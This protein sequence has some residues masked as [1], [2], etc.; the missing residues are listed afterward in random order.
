MRDRTRL[1]ER[2]GLTLVVAAAA[3]FGA[4]LWMAFRLDPLPTGKPEALG[5]DLPEVPTRLTASPT[6]VQTAVDR[7]PFREDRRR[8]PQRYRLPAERREP[9]RLA[10]AVRSVPSPPRLV[11]TASTPDGRGL[12]IFVGRSRAAQVVRV[13]D[14]IDGWRLVKVDGGTATMI[15]SDSTLV[16][17]VDQP[18]SRR[19][20]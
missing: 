20:E 6:A 3:W 17:H 19:R 4:S 11:G 2:A 9:R 16:L 7:N 12:A 15:A 10:T 13:G 1:I 14:E 8:P 18:P 5:W